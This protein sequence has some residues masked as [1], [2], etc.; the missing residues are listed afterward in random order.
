MVQKLQAFM[1]VANLG[2]HTLSSV[3]NLKVNK[4]GTSI[5]GGRYISRP[6]VAR[7]KFQSINVGSTRRVTNDNETFL[8]FLPHLW[9]KLSDKV[10]YLM[11]AM[12]QN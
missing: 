1:S 4:P 11:Y 10:L 5:K 3:S 2:T 9:H 8:L 7:G 6:H 12:P